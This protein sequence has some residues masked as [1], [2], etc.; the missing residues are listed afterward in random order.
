MKTIVYGG[1]YG[2]EGKGA[3]AEFL[4]TRA[5]A[6]GK[7]VV[8]FGENSPNSGH[9]CAAG[10]T[11]NI[12][13]ASFYADVVILGPDAVI[14]FETLKEDL[15]AVRAFNKRIEFYIH[16]HACWM[17]PEDKQ[18]E[19]DSH[20]V[21]AIG[22]TASGSGFARGQKY[23]SRHPDRVAGF[24]P[25]ARTLLA[26]GVRLLNRSQWMHMTHQLLKDYEWL[27]ECSQGVLLDTNFGVY[28]FVTSRT[29]LPQAA[30]ARNGL[31][32]FDW[33]FAGVFRTY[34]IRTGGNSGPTGGDE[35]TFEKIGVEQERATV[36]K[37]IRRIFE[38]STAD[39][40]LSTKLCPPHIIML[41]HCDY[42]KIDGPHG[43]I[44]WLAEKD[45]GNL[46]A[47]VYASWESGQF[48]EVL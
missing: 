21:S 38:F 45:L 33:T 30:L 48:K 24:S 5:I 41:T 34:P 2:S 36:T 43:V 4:V 9:T 46:K 28:P 27:F 18:A 35:T 1:Q 19:K 20:L 29:T 37:R 13:A 32:S 10:K 7:K 25:N 39:F 14:D 47:E 23:T 31:A 40:E 6:E 16:E 44:D 15:A 12:P 26:A 8:V 22:S 3:A 42:D 17:T 11:R